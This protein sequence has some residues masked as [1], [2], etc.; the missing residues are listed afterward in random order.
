MS[1]TLALHGPPLT[2]PAQLVILSN[3]HTQLPIFQ[4]S[5]LEPHRSKRA[6]W[7]RNPLAGLL[8]KVAL[9]IWNTNKL[10]PIEKKNTNTNTNRHPVW[11]DVA[12]PPPKV[13]LR[14]RESERSGV[15]CIMTRVCHGNVFGFTNIFTFVED[16]CQ[17]EEA[18]P[19][20]FF[21]V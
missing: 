2:G 1:S 14:I 6:T 5:Y 19:C 7:C 15:I 13:L 17:W 4:P 10:R 11:S 8:I 21:K 9:R 16:F 18:F 12:I 3:V 20:F